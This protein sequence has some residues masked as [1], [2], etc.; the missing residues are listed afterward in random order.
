MEASEMN[1]RFATAILCLILV[2]LTAVAPVSAMAAGTKVQIMNVDVDGARLRVGPGN[3][4]IVGSFKTGTK[5]FYL[6]EKENA[7][8]K[9]YTTDGRIGYV[10]KEFLT[11]LATVDLSQ[12]YYT[13]VDTTAYKLPTTKSNRVGKAKLHT[14]VI[15]YDIDCDWA[16]A[17][18][19]N[20]T[21]GFVK[22]SN[23]EQLVKD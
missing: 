2:M 5:L 10:Y 1:R 21:A 17:R 23:L 20:G 7:F 9:V 3:Y 12:L 11:S 14:F 13:V 16:L 19:L 8:Y 4:D 6:G 22:A 18:T 15:V